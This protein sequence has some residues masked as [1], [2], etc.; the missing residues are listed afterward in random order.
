[1]NTLSKLKNLINDCIA[2]G[3]DS[4]K[5]HHSQDTV[6]CFWKIHKNDFQYNR[7]KFSFLWIV[8]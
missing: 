3:E 5:V 4:L 6:I 7:K 1:M 8:R 2:V